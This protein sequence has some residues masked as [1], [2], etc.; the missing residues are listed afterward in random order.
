MGW[1]NFVVSVVTG[2]FGS[3]AK[4]RAETTSSPANGL[5]RIEP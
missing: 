4:L 2:N 1:E 3:D 5:R